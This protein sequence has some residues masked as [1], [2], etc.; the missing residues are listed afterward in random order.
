M[1]RVAVGRERKSAFTVL[2]ALIFEAIRLGEAEEC[3]TGFT[4]SR[5]QLTIRRLA[6]G[7]NRWDLSVEWNWKPVMGLSIALVGACPLQGQV[8]I[9]TWKRGPGVRSWQAELIDVLLADR[10]SS[11]DAPLQDRY[12]SLQVVGL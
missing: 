4:I 3:Y 12:S 10:A 1:K 6:R 8:T 5:N 7:L 9:N 11:I 2:A